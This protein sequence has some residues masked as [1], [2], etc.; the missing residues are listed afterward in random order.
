MQV[1]AQAANAVNSFTRKK[2]IQW[3]F[4]N[5]VKMYGRYNTIIFRKEF[6]SD[7]FSHMAASAF[8]RIDMAI[9]RA[10]DALDRVLCQVSIKRSFFHKLLRIDTIKLIES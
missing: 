1:A 9:M 10:E 3:L 7:I 2:M 8:T 4:L 5:R 6:A